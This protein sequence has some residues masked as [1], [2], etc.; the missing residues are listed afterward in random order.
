MFFK[1]GEME[2]T[3]VFVLSLRTVT[4]TKLTYISRQAFQ[5]NLKL[6][7]LWVFLVLDE[8]KVQFSVFRLF[9]K[10]QTSDIVEI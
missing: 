10:V 4:N 1:C 9:T 8:L 6:Q 5:S 3:S 7:Y 2:I